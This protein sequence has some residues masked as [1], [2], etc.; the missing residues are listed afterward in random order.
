LTLN[1][2][3]RPISGAI[4]AG[5][6]VVNRILSPK[7]RLTKEDF[8]NPAAA[9]RAS[10]AKQPVQPTQATQAT[11]TRTSGTPVATTTTQ[12]TQTP[13]PLTFSAEGAAA[14]KSQYGRNPSGSE[15]QQFVAGTYRPPTP[16]PEMVR[17]AART[18]TG[19]VTELSLAKK[20]LQQQYGDTFSDAELD[21][22]ARK[23]LDAGKTDLTAAEQLAKQQQELLSGQTAEARQRQLDEEARLAARR[24]QQLASY[25]AALQAQAQR[26]I[27][28]AQRVGRET[29]TTEERLLGAR[30]NLTSA[31]GANRLQDIQRQTSNTINAVNARVDAQLELEKARLEGADEETIQGLADRYD[32]ALQAENQFIIESEAALAQAKLDAQASGDAAF[33]NLVQSSIDNLSVQKASKADAALTKNIGDGYIYDEMGQRIADAEG[34]LI[35]YETT[36]EFDNFMNVGGQLFDKRTESFITPPGGEVVSSGTTPSGAKN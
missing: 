7:D 3:T 22:L 6:S 26:D 33:L 8:S 19:D 9:E 35:T 25:E 20:L 12:A 1:P 36:E 16:A 21:L 10:A 2:V 4:A 5:S 32:Q 31:V 24:E 11:P 23:Q 17:D 15:L 34:N 14:F 28:E 27:E 30:G 18:E 13:P 29:Q